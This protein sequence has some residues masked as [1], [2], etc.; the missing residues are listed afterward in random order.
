[1]N[2]QK[3]GRV[4]EPTRQAPWIGS[5]AAMPVVDGG[6]PARLYFTSRDGRSRSRIGSA[7]LRLDPVTVGA[8]DSHPALEPGA[9]GSFDDAGV[10]SSCIV[11]HDGGFYLYY[12]GWMLGVSVPFY[13]QAGLA[14]S[15]DG[16]TFRRLSDAPLLDR[17]RFDPLLTASPWVLLDGSTWRMWYVSGTAWEMV[18]GAARHRY[19]IKYA[20]S[21]DGVEWRRTGRVCIDYASPDEYAF[22]RPCVLYDE[23][24]YRMWYCCRGDTYRIGYAESL[25]GLEWTRRDAEAGLSLSS[26]G[27]DSQMMAYPVVFRHR[28]RLHMLYNGNGYG[29]TGIGLA[30]EA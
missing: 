26:E 19:H 11:R 24:R 1:M 25:D 28:G 13:L 14:V 10:T 8:V 5:H 29:L 21:N 7:E 22:G 30:T 6:D 17:A 9:L 4:F 15:E 23:G 18:G 3:R 27:W 12:T 2:W 20:E 16:R